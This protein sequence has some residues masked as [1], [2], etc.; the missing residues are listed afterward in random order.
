MKA[1]SLT[2]PIAYLA[3]V[4]VGDG[5]LTAKHPRGAYGYF[6]LRVKDSD[7]AKATADAINS[8]FGVLVSP[9][10]DERGYWMVKTY[11]GYGRFDVLRGFVPT[12]D[13]ERT[14]W[15]RGLFDSEGNAQFRR[16]PNISPNAI[17]RRVAIYSTLLCT[18]D[19]ARAYLEVLGI[20][21]ALRATKNSKS[22]KG[23]RVVFQ[24]EVSGG[25]E[26][27]DR[28]RS[29]IGTSIARKALA[30]DAIVQSYS[31]RRITSS[32]GGK[33]GAATRLARR[34]AGGIY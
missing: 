25:R 14:A 5:C 17:G 4:L 16:Q 23:D 34:D 30:L 12:T 3:G 27:Y 18:L 24:L 10:R 7:F 28:F 15:L 21:T 20:R 8:G 11:N 19:A 13:G 32:I 6:Q 33:R 2:Q 1:L 29:M 9:R 31:D 22:H 26:Q